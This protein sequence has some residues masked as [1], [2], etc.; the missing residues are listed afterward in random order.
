MFFILDLCNISP[1]LNFLYNHAEQLYMQGFWP[2]IGMTIEML[3]LPP[4][5]RHRNNFLLIK[6]RRPVTEL[7]GRYQKLLL[8]FSEGTPKSY[9]PR[10]CGT[11]NGK[12]SDLEGSVLT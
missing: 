5:E 6:I 3:T 1:S 10:P 7:L 11:S 12:K 4:G 2:K 8:F 9:V